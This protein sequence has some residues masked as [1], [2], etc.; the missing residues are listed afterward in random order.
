MIYKYINL[1]T[2]ILCFITF[3]ATSQIEQPRRAEIELRPQENFFTVVSAEE[4]GLI[5]FR[6]K[7]DIV[8]NGTTAWEFIKYDTGLH[9]EWIQNYNVEFDQEFLGYDYSRNDL[10]LLFKRGNYQQSEY[11]MIRMNL[12][13]GD[14]AQF[15]INNLMPIVLSDFNVIGQAALLSG[16]VNNRAVVIHY[17]Y[18]E[19]KIKVL[20]GM[21][22]K[23]TEIT[24]IK[25]DDINRS[26][27]VVMTEKTVDRRNTVTAKTFDENG[28]LLKN[29][30][31]NPNDKLNIIYGRSTTFDDDMQLVVGTYSLGNSNFS[32]GI[33]VAK[34]DEQ[35]QEI[36]NHYNF[37]DLHNF[38]TYMKAKRENR[39]KQR[40]ARR[41][42]KGKNVRFNYRLLVHDIIEKDD[43]YI[44]IAE[45]YYPKYSHSNHGIMYGGYN[46]F[47]S[48]R[49]YGNTNGLYFDGYKYT[50]AIV[51]G[52]DKNGKLLW[53]NSF[54]INDVESFQLET[55]VK[56]SVEKD[57]IV[58]LYL[59]E[60]VVRSKIINDD[61]VLEGKAFNE[62]KLKFEEDVVKNGDTKVGGLEYWY[63]NNF[64]AFGVQ[65]IRNNKA[66]NGVYSREVF[67]INKISYN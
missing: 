26:F 63:D 62:I 3:N 12:N 23:Y 38:F 54:E 42:V 19:K 20:P 55:F 35:G 31:L 48:F 56:A 40:I 2:G 36:F 67:Y 30:M 5:M 1:F 28:E 43:N 7:D 13:N 64:I 9:Q 8:K 39:I 25:I 29:V 27:S 24:E 49:R 34:I 18:I 41:K 4:K 45:A 14:T 50:H 46:Q 61:K 47:N 32:R 16:Q 44:L 58:L 59:Y 33:Y 65:K 51:A 66:Q 15:K 52:F 10:F 11:K 57:K 60:N 21:Y 6:E 53:D 17:D 37:G 22:R